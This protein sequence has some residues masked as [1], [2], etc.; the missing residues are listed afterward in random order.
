MPTV[1]RLIKNAQS[2][3]ALGVLLVGYYVDEWRGGK[4]WGVVDGG[5][6]TK[7]FGN[8]KAK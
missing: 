5:F 6:T 8:K 1:N 4:W 7:G 3:P 2:L